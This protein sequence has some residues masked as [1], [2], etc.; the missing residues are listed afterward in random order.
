[1]KQKSGSGKKNKK[2]AAG[3]KQK[4]GSGKNNINK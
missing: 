1:V 2:V 3:K 4:S